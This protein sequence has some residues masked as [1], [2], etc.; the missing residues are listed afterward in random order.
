MDLLNQSGATLA[1]R[2]DERASATSSEPAFYFSGSSRTLLAEHEGELLSVT[3]R[4]ASEVSALA[5]RALIEAERS[6]LQ[7]AL[8]VGVVPF[9]GLSRARLSVPRRV[10]QLEAPPRLIGPPRV[11]AS[12]IA[13]QAP[14]SDEEQRFKVGVRRAIAAI[15]AGRLRKVVLSRAQSFELGR[16]PQLSA[17]LR[18]LREREPDA[19]IFS[20]S[21]A[22]PGRKLVGASPELLVSKSGRAVSSRPLAG[23]ARRSL[24]AAQDRA[25]AEGLLRSVKD[26]HEHEIVVERI[27]E[28]LRPLLSEVERDREPS[29]VAT[30]GMWHLASHIRGKLKDP[31]TSSLQLALALHPTPAVCG[32]PT[33]AARAFIEAEE[34]FERGD[35]TGAVGYMDRAGDGEWVVALRCAELEGTR[36]RVFAGAGIVET[37]DPEAELLET[38]GKMQTML[39]AL[40]G[41]ESARS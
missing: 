32:A 28:D 17:L 2:R 11:L 31:Q 22:E 38:R 15:R 29:L 5:D 16:A 6:S 37:S 19:F 39:D 9:V 27:V 7:P 30:S 23:S 20:V 18:A 26:R 41:A 34:P 14:P 1:P 4:D 3:G 33:G 13:V 10:V 25:A 12:S 36:A 21:G 24:D 35:F 40:L 8:L